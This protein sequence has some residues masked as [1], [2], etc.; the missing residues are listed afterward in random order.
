MDDL[1][2]ACIGVVDAGLLRR[3]RM[4]D[5][6]IFDA[7]IGERAGGVEA[8][9]LQIACQHLHGRHPAGLNCGD[10]L[11]A[12]G[13]REVLAAPEPGVLRIGEVLDCG[14]AGRRDVEHARVRQRVLQA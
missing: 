10:E 11:G 13:E 6:L 5:E 7:V 8:E 1:K 12:R 3:E 4:L 2:C 14:G 9:G